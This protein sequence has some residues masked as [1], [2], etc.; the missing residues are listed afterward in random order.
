LRGIDHDD[1]PI[2]AHL[3]R[4]GAVFAGK[5]HLHEFAYGL[6]GENPHFGDGPNLRLPGRV[7]GGSS[8]GSVAAVAG[9]ILPLALGTDTGGS[10]R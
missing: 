7:S 1:A 10:V 2:V 3:R 8:S 4:A 9:G 5:V 6:T